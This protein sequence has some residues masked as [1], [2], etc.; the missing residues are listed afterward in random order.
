MLFTQG[1]VFDMRQNPG[2]LLTSAVDV[3]SLFVPKNSDIV[4]AKGRGFPSLLYRSRV[5]PMVTSATKV[6]V[7]VSGNTASA[8]EIVSGAIQDHDVGVILG[9]DRTYGKGLVQNVEQLPFD[10]ALKFTVAKYYTPSGRCIQSTKYTEGG[11]GKSNEDSSFT[12]TKIAEK[13]RGDFY[14][15]GGRLVRDGG[16]IEA[17]MKVAAPKASALEV[18]L[19]RANLLNDYAAR[20][21]KT[22]E[23]T[24]SFGITDD[25][26]QDFQ[27]F[28]LQK[29]DTNEIDLLAQIYGQPFDTLRKVLKQSEYTHSLKDELEALQASILREMKSDFGKY[30]K[31]IKED[32]EQAI[33]A[34][35]LPES[36]LIEKAITHDVQ[37]D[38]ARKLMNNNPK[39]DTLLARTSSRTAAVESSSLATRQLANTLATQS[40]G[41]S[42]IEGEK[43]IGVRLNLNF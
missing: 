26:Y 15:R 20:W 8:A 18:S 35:Y 16:G 17:D 29:Q 38:A 41:V 43:E 1:L 13:D 37:V 21:S 2:G 31:D 24:N 11:G 28:V 6:V 42:P 4:S 39:F 23:L 27:R 7:L 9:T 36:M 12:A 34:R 30:R 19:L 3:A 5:D 40:F 10:T 33:L 32:L 22:H 25:V 14:T